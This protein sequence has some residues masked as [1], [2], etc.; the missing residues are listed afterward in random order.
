MNTQSE[1]NITHLLLVL[2]DQI[3]IANNYDIPL[4]LSTDKRLLAIFTQLK[5]QP[6]LSFTLKDWAKKVGASER[7]LSRVCAK[8][9]S[10]SFSL[11]R[12]NIR[13]VLSLQLLDSALA[14]ADD[15]YPYLNYLQET[16]I[17]LKAQLNKNQ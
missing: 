2:R 13:L 9:F 15:S 17:R 5:Q 11:W 4:L 1:A 12:Q 7:T 8:E 3:V 16:H 14:I 10:Q 6:D